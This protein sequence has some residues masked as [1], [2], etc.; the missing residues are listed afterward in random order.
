MEISL[1]AFIVM[2]VVAG[3][4]ASF[5]FL[6]EFNFRL[7]ATRGVTSLNPGSVTWLAGLATVLAFGILFYTH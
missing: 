3:I 6:S 7:P 5:T 1:I 4:F 2:A